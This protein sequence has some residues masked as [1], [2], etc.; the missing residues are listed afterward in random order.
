MVKK[1]FK[2]V[3]KWVLTYICSITIIHKTHMYTCVHI[4]Y[5]YN[6][7]NCIVK[8][9]KML[10]SLDYWNNLCLCDCTHSC[11]SVLIHTE[12]YL[13]CNPFCM[14]F[15]TNI[16]IQV[17]QFSPGNYQSN[18]RLYTLQNVSKYKTFS[19]KAYNYLYFK[20]CVFINKH[21]STWWK[22]M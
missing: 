20:K 21:I 6:Q 7:Y 22:K 1:Y 8:Y 14:Y 2:V 17:A 12:I 18:Y 10:H 3:L 4:Y 16:E 15:K 13:L 9:G 11:I 19:I 5:I